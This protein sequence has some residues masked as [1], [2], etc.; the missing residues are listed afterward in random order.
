MQRLVAP[1]GDWGGDARLPGPGWGTP[2]LGERFRL[3][4]E[5]AGRQQR[6]GAAG[7]FLELL[8]EGHAGL[9]AL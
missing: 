1:S 7:R 8:E 9:G 4:G 3:V 2:V 6:C 5:P